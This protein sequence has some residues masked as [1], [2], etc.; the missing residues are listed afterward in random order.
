MAMGGLIHSFPPVVDGRSRILILGTMPSAASL[1]RGFYYGRPRNAYWRIM[2]RAFNANPPVGIEEKRAL[3]LDNQ[4]A[5][6]DVLASC[7]RPGSL[8]A[9]IR[10]ETPND[11]RAFFEQW[12]AIGAIL[13]NGGAAHRLFAKYD[14]GN[15]L[16]ILKMPSTSPAHTMP[17]EAKCAAWSEG[18]ILAKARCLACSQP[19]SS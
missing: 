6:W 11:F 13:S 7:V 18:I 3:I 12:P 15:H 5:L 10:E 19:T 1:T 9:D 8:D 16:P 2:A 17:F 14:A 4:I